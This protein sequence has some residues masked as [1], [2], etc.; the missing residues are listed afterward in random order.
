MRRE[1]YERVVK[2][3]RRLRHPERKHSRERPKLEKITRMWS[4]KG[5][6]FRERP[7]P[8]IWS[9]LHRRT[10]EEPKL[11]RTARS[12]AERRLKEGD[13]VGYRVGV[14]GVKAYDRLEHRLMRC[15]PEV[16]PFDGLTVKGRGGRDRMGQRT[17][18]FQEAG[19]IPGRKPHYEGLYKILRVTPG[20]G[21]Y[22]TITTS[23]RTEAVGRD[24][25]LGRRVPV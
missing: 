20:H 4:R 5:M 16:R 23:A 7:R 10:G 3:D 9:A 13:P 25:L 17:F 1:H 8:S 15:R 19:V 22:R 21:L 12:V 11:V 2:W 18:Q 24:L 14:E 6:A